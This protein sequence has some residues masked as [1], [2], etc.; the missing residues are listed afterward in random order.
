MILGWPA[1]EAAARDEMN[2]FPDLKSKAEK[3]DYFIEVLDYSKDAPVGKLLVKTNKQSFRVHYAR[4]DGDWAVLSCSNDRVLVYALSSGEEK[5][6]VF[7]EGVNI[8]AVAGLYAVPTSTGQL[9]LYRLENSQVFQQY[10]FPA[11]VALQKFSE[12]GK[13]MFVLTSDQTAYVFDL[14]KN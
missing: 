2:R 11:R 8:S 4:I 5:G 7:G 10:Q 1:S 12:D 3:E 13:R 9:T 6:H 14:A